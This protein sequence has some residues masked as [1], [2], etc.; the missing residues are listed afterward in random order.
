MW[1]RLF[2]VAVALSLALVVFKLRFA[3]VRANMRLYRWKWSDKKQRRYANLTAA[4]FFVVVL[5]WSGVLLTYDF[6]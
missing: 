3:L 6:P 5:I 1:W 2:L 4:F